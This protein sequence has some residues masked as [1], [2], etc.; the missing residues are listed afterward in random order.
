MLRLSLDFG[1]TFADQSDF[2][3]LTGSISMCLLGLTNVA[4]SLH[5]I[6]KSRTFFL[7]HPHLVAASKMV[8]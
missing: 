1:V 6:L 7:K 3:S 5:I 2:F 4:P 8:G